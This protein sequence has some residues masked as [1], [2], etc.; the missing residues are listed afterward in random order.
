MNLAA[1]FKITGDNI[2]FLLLKTMKNKILVIDDAK[3]VTMFF[4]K[5][6]EQNGYEVTTANDYASAINELHE[7]TFDLIFSDIV[8][9]T[10]TG[11][12][13]LREVKKLGLS[14]PVILITGFPGVETASDAVRLGAYDYIVK[15]I[16]KKII[17]HVTKTALQHKS[18]IDENLKFQSNL[19][20]IFRSV[21][22]GIITVNKDL[23]VLAINEAATNICGFSKN[24][25]KGVEI[26]TLQKNC[27]GDCINAISETI[28]KKN[29]V[30]RFHFDCKNKTRRNDTVTLTT[31]PLIT[32]KNENPGCILIVK[33][34]ARMA[35]STRGMKEFQQFQNIIGKSDKMQ[36]IYTLVDILTDVK[37]P[38][39]ITGET[40][41]GKELV[42]EALHYRGNRK[43]KPLVKVNCSALSDELIT[44]ELFGHV[45]GSFTGA[46]DDK[47]GRFQMADGG[48][49]FLDEIG[50]ISIKTQLQ[51]LRVLQELE[52][53]R[54]GE[55][56]SI[57]VDVRVITATNQ[58]LRK[59][60]KQG[61]FREDLYHR[62]KVVELQLPPL[63]ERHEDIPLLVNHFI[64][65]FNEKF[66]K[67]VVSIS[68]AVMKVFT[69]YPWTGNVR[70]LEHIMEHTFILCKK[71]VIEISDLPSDLNTYL[72]LQL[73]SSKINLKNE[74]QI[75]VEAL[76][77]TGWNKA[78]A[79][80]ILGI[81]RKTIYLKIKKH[82]ITQ[83]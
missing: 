42:A 1:T 6:L 10:N 44:S 81:D 30:E 15:P 79:A 16:K 77:K 55:S 49:L 23:T 8:L 71:P 37:T 7:T 68:D 43:N 58:E 48:T 22:D 45:K 56:T 33:P 40:G 29:P 62:L 18:E 80:R 64:T 50:N 11:I 57:K 54:V 75:I 69:R 32:N 61:S 47:V 63:R 3:T 28:E 36:E 21:K 65:K 31:F 74:P 41:T 53:E 12:D 76:Q 2:L 34:E 82:N 14:S 27:S 17:L 20:A 26:K 5:L 52:F 9:D 24:E 25:S 51:L 4:K 73:E 46:I 38:V 67:T 39:L 13:V 83:E 35:F 60:V 70:E 19:E 78:K 72:N 66:N 59:M